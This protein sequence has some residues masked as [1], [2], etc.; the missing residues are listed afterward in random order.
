MN[1]LGKNDEIEPD[2]DGF[3]KIHLNSYDYH[4]EMIKYVYVYT[5][6]LLNEIV[7]ITV[8]AFVKNKYRLRN[9]CY[10]K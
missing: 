1:S 8:K 9:S 5:N 7:D 6:D 10:I 3:L 2:Y 4:G